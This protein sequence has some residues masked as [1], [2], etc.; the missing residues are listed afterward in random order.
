MPEPTVVASP[1][2]CPDC[3]TTLY[4][5][6]QSPGPLCMS[7]VAANAQFYRNRP[8]TRIIALHGAQGAGKDTVAD[9]LV[10]RY[11]FTKLAFADRL[12]EICLA[13]NPIVTFEADKGTLHQIAAGERPTL[14]PVRLAE[15][16]SRHGWT[17]AKRCYP[18][19]RRFQTAQANEV[20]QDF[21]GREFFAEFV[22]DVITNHPGYWVV[23]DLRFAHEYDV[24]VDAFGADSLDVWWVKRP[25]SPIEHRHE[26]RSESWHPAEGTYA[27]IVNDGTLEDLA[28]AVTVTLAERL[29]F[30][31]TSLPDEELAS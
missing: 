8:T 23:P 11:G 18:E 9:I 14:R 24:M 30:E 22:V 7:R 1:A 15:I 27:E 3:G 31:A 25:N 6:S 29:G 10:D 12:R 5:R 17:E 16:V 2:P 19:V 13:A 21:V 4:C 20:F 26:A 28:T